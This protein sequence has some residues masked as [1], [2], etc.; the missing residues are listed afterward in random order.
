[1]SVENKNGQIVRRGIDIQL[2]HG[3][4]IEIRDGVEIGAWTVPDLLCR[5]AR[6]YRV[7][8]STESVSHDRVD[9]SVQERRY[10]VLEINY[11]DAAIVRVTDKFIGNVVTDQMRFRFRLLCCDRK[12]N[13]VTIAQGELPSLN[14]SESDLID[15]AVLEVRCASRDEKKKHRREKK[16]KAAIIHA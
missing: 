15:F 16:L 9:D 11:R 3:R 14:I 8:F 1:M 6:L 13:R 4:A 7:G 12:K 2:V 10:P 5:I